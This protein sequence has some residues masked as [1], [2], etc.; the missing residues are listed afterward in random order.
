MSK[1]F[2]S[3]KERMEPI[4]YAYYQLKFARDSFYRAQETFINCA[5]NARSQPR[6]YAFHRYYNEMTGLIRNTNIL[7]KKVSRIRRNS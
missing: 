5:Y 2:K 7:F 1:S 6:K 3:S 4:D